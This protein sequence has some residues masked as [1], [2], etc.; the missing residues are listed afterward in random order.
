MCN[1]GSTGQ[2]PDQYPGLR[3]GAGPDLGLGKLGS[4][5]EASTTWGPP[6]ISCYLLFFD[7]LG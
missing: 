6:H 2:Y 7:I 4:C 5:P 1:I 3:G